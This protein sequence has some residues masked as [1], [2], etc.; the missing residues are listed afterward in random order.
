MDSS[1]AWFYKICVNG[2]LPGFQVLKKFHFTQVLMVGIGIDFG[3]SNSVAATFDGQRITLVPLE[4][5]RAY[6][7]DCDPS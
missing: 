7:A 4:G 3:T 6:N 2:K 5:G 1:V